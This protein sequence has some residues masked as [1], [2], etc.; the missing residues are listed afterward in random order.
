MLIKENTQLLKVFCISKQL[1]FHIN[2]LENL[3][4]VLVN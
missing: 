3:H 1:E 2:N 4:F